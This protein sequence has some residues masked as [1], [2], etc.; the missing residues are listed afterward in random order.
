MIIGHAHAD[1]RPV[2]LRALP[3][4]GKKYRRVGER[5]EVVRVVRKLPQVVGVHHRELSKRLLK[6]GIELVSLA[7]PN[8]RLQAHAADH[9]EDD[10]VTRSQAC[11]NQVLIERGL[12]NTRIGNPKNRI[13]LLDVVG[14][15]HAR[16]RLTIMDDSAI[17]VLSKSHIEG[18]IAHV[19]CV[20]QV[21][22]ELLNVRMAAEWE[23]SALGSRATVLRL[24]RRS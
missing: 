13:C 4:N 10:R 21:E 15:A 12:Q 8:W 24:R 11:Q 5:R 22:P 16:L 17:Q 23:Q 6:A 14:K 1:R 9:V 3:C 20:L 19:D 18:P 2:N 7:R